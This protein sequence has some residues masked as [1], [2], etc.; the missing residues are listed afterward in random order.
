[1]NEQEIKDAVASARKHV[2]D[3]RQKMIT[4]LG[5]LQEALGIVLEEI[6][7]DLPPGLGLWAQN[8]VVVVGPAIDNPIA[9][10]TL[11]CVEEQDGAV[12]HIEYTLAVDEEKQEF[13]DLKDLARA[14]AEPLIE[15]IY[16]LEDQ[17]LAMEAQKEEETKAI[18]PNAPTVQPS[19]PPDAAAH[20]HFAWKGVNRQG[21][22]KDGITPAL[23]EQ[24]ARDNLAKLGF[25]VTE[26]GLSTE[27]PDVH[28]DDQRPDQTPE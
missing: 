13:R 14:L 18:D 6:G 4:A 3:R 22:P 27:I 5:E 2:E 25:T 16:K 24:E 28:D 11:V 17:R 12:S 15:D 21:M 19:A 20:Q 7:D 1:M 10:A 26:I 8:D 23:N 9:A